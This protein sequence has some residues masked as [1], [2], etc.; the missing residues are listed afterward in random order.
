MQKAFEA[1]KFGN[2]INKL[3]R[4]PDLNKKPE[5]IKKLKKLGT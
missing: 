5:L 1:V 2:D 4:D 3:A